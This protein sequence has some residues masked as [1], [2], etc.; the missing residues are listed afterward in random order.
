MCIFI[1]TDIEKER[2]ATVEVIFRGHS[3]SSEIMLF[4]GP[5]TIS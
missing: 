2:Y 3:I 1:V 5:H 4:D